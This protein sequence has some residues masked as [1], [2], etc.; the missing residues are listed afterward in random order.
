MDFRFDAEE[1]GLIEQAAQTMSAHLSADRYL[2]DASSRSGWVAV[3]RDGWLHAGLAEGLGGGGLPLPLM[4]GIAREA[5]RLL[6]GDGFVNNAVLIPSLLAAAQQGNALHDLV[7]HPGFLVCDGRST[8]LHASSSGATPWCFGVETGLDAY[9]L[10]GEGH[11]LLRY[12]SQAW[13][14]EPTGVLALGVGT[15]YIAEDAL[16]VEL[17]TVDEVP[18]AFSIDA[19]I[20]H[21]AALAGLGEKA[22]QETVK[23]VLLREQFGSVIGRFQA[24]KHELA[25]VAVKLEVAWN[26]TLYASLRATEAA[27]ST[28]LLQ[29]ATAADVAVRA[30]TQF[31]GGIAITNEHP[32]HLYLKTAETGRWRFGAADDHALRIA[33]STLGLEESA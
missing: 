12:E 19:Q 24:V 4:A 17:G 1:I 9:V 6:A 3:A 22:L 14:V 32:T 8:D 16:P 2:Y 23:Y 21:A 33:L 18:S 25:S 29:V 13:S 27:V 30:M 7:T 28:A 31:H 10:S 20:L 26:S 15:V 11:R 5:G